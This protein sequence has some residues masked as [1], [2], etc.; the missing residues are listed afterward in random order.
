LDFCCSPGIQEHMDRFA[1]GCPKIYRLLFKRAACP[2]FPLIEKASVDAMRHWLPDSFRRMVKLKVW[3]TDDL[4]FRLPTCRTR[5]RVP[6][7]GVGGRPTLV[8]EISGD[9]SR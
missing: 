3:G 2:G 4:L 9:S 5:R 1:G 7:L 6:E 8:S